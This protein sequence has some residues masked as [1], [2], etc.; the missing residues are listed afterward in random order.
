MDR[1]LDFLLATQNLSE[2]ECVTAARSWA[3]SGFLPPAGDA[4]PPAVS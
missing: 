2:W 3:E 1:L 4:P